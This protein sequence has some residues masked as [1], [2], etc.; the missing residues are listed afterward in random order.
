M[1]GEDKI[2]IPKELLCHISPPLRRLVDSKMKE[3]QTGI[4]DF[5]EDWAIQTIQ[6]V[7][8]FS[9]RSDYSVPKPS[10]I[11]ISKTPKFSSISAYVHWSKILH[12]QSTD[13]FDNNRSHDNAYS[14]RNR[15]QIENE[16]DSKNKMQ[17][18]VNYT[19]LTNAINRFLAYR[20]SQ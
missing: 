1:V 13:H 8:T 9:Y 4:A 14:T 19:R 3:G 10:I 2:R 20:S 11:P 6:C 12:S 5:S 17:Q 15:V 18:L 16:S 7:V